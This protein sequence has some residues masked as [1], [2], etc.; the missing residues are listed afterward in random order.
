MVLAFERLRVVFEE[1]LLDLCLG[2]GELLHGKHLVNLFRD[3]CLLLFNELLLL[4]L[5]FLNGNDFLLC[6]VEG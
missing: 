3:V 5:L 4:H 1:F 6:D 2:H